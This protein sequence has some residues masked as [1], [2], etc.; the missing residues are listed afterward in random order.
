MCVCAF[1]SADVERK[2]KRHENAVELSIP[3]EAIYYGRVHR[4]SSVAVMKGQSD[5]ADAQIRT[6]D[7]GQFEEIFRSV[8]NE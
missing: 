4:G 7:D 6:K 5:A 2:T 8:S 3:L 1:G